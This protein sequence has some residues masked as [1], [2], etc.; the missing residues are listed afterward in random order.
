MKRD[1]LFLL[2]PSFVDPNYPTQKFYCWH[3][4]LMEGLLVS[5]PYMTAKLD[6]ERIAWPRPRNKLI[7]ILGRENQTLHVLILAD[8]A[9]AGIETGRYGNHRFVDDKDAI[10]RALSARYGIP[11]PAASSFG[12]HR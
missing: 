4:M 7:E 5:F 3:C 10:L 8:N 1:K 11:D 6:V 9:P 2:E 12:V